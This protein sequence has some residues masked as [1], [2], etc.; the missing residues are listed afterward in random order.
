MVVVPTEKHVTLHYARTGVEWL[1][2]WLSGVGLMGLG[3]L[4]V[5]GRR[6]GTERRRTRTRS[7]APAVTIAP[8]PPGH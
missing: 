1:G 6:A 3:V 5:W 7:P 4:V 8:P 2:L